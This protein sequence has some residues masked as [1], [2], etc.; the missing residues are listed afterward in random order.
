MTSSC[1]L[2]KILE[3]IEA[4]LSQRVFQAKKGLVVFRSRHR[5]PVCFKRC[6]NNFH[7]FAKFP[8]HVCSFSPSKDFYTC[9]IDQ[10]ESTFGVLL[11]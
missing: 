9:I 1:L 10:S 2:V 11:F 7:R 4:L 8:A 6:I 3:L 5:N